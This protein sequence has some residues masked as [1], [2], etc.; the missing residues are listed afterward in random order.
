MFELGNEDVYGTLGFDGWQVLLRQHT[1]RLAAKHF[2]L[3]VG[4]A[5]A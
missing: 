4:L 2:A 3:A 5:A 1:L